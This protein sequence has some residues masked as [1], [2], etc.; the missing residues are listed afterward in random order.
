MTTAAETYE[1]LDT[2]IRAQ[3]ALPIEWI[4]EAE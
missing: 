2:F 1:A 4:G 3:G